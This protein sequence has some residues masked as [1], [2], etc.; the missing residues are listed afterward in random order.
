MC[1]I[2]SRLLPVWRRMPAEAPE[3]VGGVVSGSPFA[4]S[5]AVRPGA[6]RGTDRQQATDADPGEGPGKRTQQARVKEE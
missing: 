4:A 6:A 5:H 3:T 1:R 2:D